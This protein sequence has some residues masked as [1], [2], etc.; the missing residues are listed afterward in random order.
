MN[1]ATCFLISY[2]VVNAIA[3]VASIGKARSVMTPA[4]AVVLLFIYAGLI[5][6]VLSAVGV[7]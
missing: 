5:L 2:F 1:L 7:L 6:V 4:A 3:G